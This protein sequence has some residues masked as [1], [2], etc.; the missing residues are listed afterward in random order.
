MESTAQMNSFRF[1]ALVG[2]TAAVMALGVCVRAQFSA[3][4][5]LKATPTT[6]K[7]VQVGKPFTISVS[8]HIDAP[9]HIQGNPAKEGYI[10]TEMEV[11]PLKGFKVDKVVYP[12]PMIAAIG[13]DRLP[14]YEGI[15]RIKADITA[16]KSM[17]PGKYMLPVTLKYQGCDE[18]KCFPP[19]TLSTKAAVQVTA[20]AK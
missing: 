20:G 3:P 7:S 19:T 4:K 10:A 5:F 12:K 16:E 15:I 17:K 14:V 8:V 6:P 11:G 9:Y 18:Q 1:A 2:T 13:G